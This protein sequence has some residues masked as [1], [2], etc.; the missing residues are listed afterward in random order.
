MKTR[1]ILI[2]L[3]FVAMFT[4]IVKAQDCGYFTMSKGNVFGYQNLDAKGKVSGT[5]KTTCID[6]VKVG[7]STNFKVK[8]E[9]TDPKNS[10]P[11]SHE[12]TMRCEDGRF[13]MD[14][15]SF[16][17]PKSMESFKG[18]EVSVDSKDMMYP[19]VLSAGQSLPEASITISAGSGGMSIM[20]MVVNVTNRKVVG[21]EL[22]TVPAGTFECYKLTYDVE[23]KVMFKIN[24]AVV[25]YINMGVGTVK[26]ETFD[27]KGK[28]AATTVLSE[29]KR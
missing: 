22:V 13:Y 12:Y 6:V 2:S 8:S 3:M 5:T 21:N 25:E 28:L 20:N 27:K 24:T 7:A 19:S 15:Q 10:T 16:M 23:T 14:M 17:D 11:S 18:M 29:L 4:G 1:K 26:T 9:Y